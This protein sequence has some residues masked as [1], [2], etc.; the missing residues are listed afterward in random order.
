MFRIVHIMDRFV[1]FMFYTA[2]FAMIFAWLM[3]CTDVIMRY[4]LNSP[5]LWSVEVNEYIL[6]GTTFLSAAWVLRKEG[7]VAIDSALHLFNPRNRA[8]IS[9]FTS[10]LGAVVCL[11]IFWFGMLKTVDQFQLGT[12]TSDKALEIPYFILI[13]IIPVGFL[14]FAYQFLK[15][16]YAHLIT[17][18][19]LPETQQATKD[20]YDI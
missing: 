3:T 18:K 13:A 5:I 16:G 11:V 19:D 17:W 8:L 14:L 20:S 4:F 7:H 12:V 10:I 15:Q 6:A 2:C 1:D 9:I